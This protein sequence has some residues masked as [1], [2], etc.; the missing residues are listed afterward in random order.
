[1]ECYTVAPL[2]IKGE[3]MGINEKIIKSIEIM[4]DKKLSELA[5]DRTVTG[6]IVKETDGGYIV[7]FEGN[8]VTIKSEAQYKNG[9]IVRVHLPQNN[10]NNGY[11]D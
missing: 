10:L 9:S 11:I 1:M 3:H 8:K 2:Y 6:R 5:F 4:L 7:A